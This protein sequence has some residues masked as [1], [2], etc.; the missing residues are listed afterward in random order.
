[1][2][3]AID[4]CLRFTMALERFLSQ[5]HNAIGRCAVTG[6]ER[7]ERRLIRANF[8][9]ERVPSPDLNVDPASELAQFYRDWLP[10]VPDGPFMVQAK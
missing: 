2:S 9:L 4:G 10:V 3:P 6:I 5:G 7:I 8:R 1:M